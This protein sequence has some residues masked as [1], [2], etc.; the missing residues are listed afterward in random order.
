[1]DEKGDPMSDSIRITV[2]MLILIPML[3]ASAWAQEYAFTYT[4]SDQGDIVHPDSLGLF[5]TY[6]TNTGAVADTYLVV[7]DKDLPVPWQAMACL[8]WGC[9]FDQATVPLEPDS[10]VEVSVELMPLGFS[11]AGTVTMRVTS[12]GDTTLTAALPVTAI[13][14]SGVD[15]LI[16]DDD[17]GQ[18][19]ETY[20]QAALDSAGKSHGTL[21][22]L[23]TVIDAGRLAPFSAVVWFTGEATPAL[24][25]EDR[26]AISAYL[27]DGG[28]LFIS[29]QDIASALCDVASGESDSSTVAWFERTFSAAYEE[30]YGGTLMLEGIAGN[31][32]SAGLTL[33]ISGGDGADNQTSPDILEPIFGATAFAY[34][35]FHYADLPDGPPMAAFTVSTGVYRA[36]F[37]AFGFEAIDNAADRALVMERIMDY[38]EGPTP[39]E[40]EVVAGTLPQGF[41]L[42]PNYPN[43]FNATTAVALFVPG[44]HAAPVTLKI[45][46]ILGQE[47]RKLM[48]GPVSPGD[49]LILWDGTDETGAV[50]ASGVYFARLAAEHFSQT[51]KIVF[52]R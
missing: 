20:Y 24:T 30:E 51:R 13:T 50:L 26:E 23:T 37:F 52:A 22:N 11:G 34:P 28:R 35:I 33:S 29:G 42:S 21:D 47:V 19:Y 7:I 49:Y 38:F 4:C 1:M 6:L 41:S 2:I 17:G 5:Y 44:E 27:G 25:G 12:W 31:T 14:N 32:I 48:D 36:V 46:N 8:P 9:F 43:P 18:E 16:V 15:V 10:S 39:V 45:Y 3:V 40:G